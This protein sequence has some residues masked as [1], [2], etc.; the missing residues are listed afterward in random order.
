M[1][2]LAS[3]CVRKP[4]LATVLILFFCVLGV[5]G[6]M[7]LGVDRFPKVDLPFVTVVTRLPGAAPPEVETEVTEKIEEAVN[8]V[9]GIDDLIS[10][11][12]EGVSVVQI[13]FV[14]EKDVDTAVQEVRDRVSQIIPELPRDAETPIVQKLDPDASPVL[15]LSL[16]ADRPIREITELADRKVRPSLETVPGVGQVTLIGGRKRQ[17]NVW[18]DPA[19]MRA[20]G[21]SA[22]E[23]QRAI[24]GQNLMVPGGAIETGPTRLSLRLRGRV[25]KVEE[26]GQLV[27]RERDGHIL[28][29][30]D[31]AR[32][33]DG[34]QEAVTAA[35]QDG[36][37]SVMLSIRKQ[38]GENTVAVVDAIN[39][40]VAQLRPNLPSGYTL[41]VV[42]DNSA[43]TRTSVEA[44]REH[45][46]LGGLFASLVVLLFLG[47][48]RSTLIAALAIPTS[49]VSTFA[50]MKA[51]GF[52]LNTITLLALA[53]AVGIVIDDA[54]V[55]LENI[56][57]HIHEKGEKPF[58][59]AI[60]ATK[61]I[62][63]AVLATTLSLIA[64]FLPMAFMGGIPGRFLSSFG[65]TMAFS[66]AVSLLVSF[67]LT[68][69]L[70]ARWLSAPKGGAHQK[71]FLE[72]V[73]DTFYLPIERAYDRSLRW[74]LRHRWVAVVMA[75]AT[76]GSCVPLMQAVPKGFLPKSDEAQFEV[77]MR[78]P[79][80]TSLASTQLVSERLGRQLRELPEVRSTLVT[81]GDNNERAP[82]LAKIFVQMTHPSTRKESQDQVMARVRRDFTSKLPPEWRVNVSEVSAFSG[83]GTQAAVMM[84]VTGPDFKE[85]T[86]YANTLKE[87]LK[88]I[89]GAVD[90]D[91]NLI[92]G[93][94]EV[95]AFIN[96]SRAADLGVQVSDVA[97]TLQLFVGGVE[98][99]S[100][101][102]N[103]NIYDVRLRAEPTARD[104][105]EALSQL[106]V[107]SA[108]AG[109]VPLMDV[110]HVEHEEGAATINRLNRQRQVLLTANTAP[111][112]GSGT[113]LTQLEQAVKDLKLP[114]GYSAKPLGQSRE[115]GRTMTNFA[116]AFG[117]A[118]VFMYLILAAQFESW[119]HPLTILL[120]LPLTVPFALISL[121]VFRQSLDIYSMLGLMV[122]FGVVKKNSILQIDHA[123]QLRAAGLEKT[124][125]IVVGSRDRLRPIL[126]TTLSFVAGMLPLVTSTGIGAG[127]NRATAGVVVGGQTLSL[128]LTLLV[129]P[130]AYSLLDSLAERAKRFFNSVFS[131]R[132][133]EETG[134]ADVLLAYAEPPHTMAKGVATVSHVTPEALA[135]TAPPARRAEPSP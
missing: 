21:V 97:A 99:S 15:F 77:N 34:E 102:E 59:A 26:L 64:V 116:I 14:L 42:R 43:T 92:L 63:L 28:R 45:L 48:W 7:Q 113:V 124:E 103:G 101:V 11:T 71:P 96:R 18:L 74:M 13:G 68:P 131:P 98:V 86:R 22:A 52:T 2:W 130:V 106:T 3:L 105:V 114:P 79:E 90:A 118:F 84:V 40:R 83:G 110:L 8:T 6:Y 39:E 135:H 112:T 53:L 1:Q 54:I 85:L 123:N 115:I 66:I 38:S 93:K 120:S 117:L 33:E 44:V 23:L 16:N 50:L 82:N 12:S 119:L 30:S 122:L 41:E 17:V 62:G 9:S 126:M 73:T 95:S 25:E 31:V 104:S 58:P 69:M 134:Q 72:R 109:S 88:A 91:T 27:L 60:L 46:V 132:T 56:F 80:G 65:W 47:S 36:K 5:A 133:P 89:P 111:G 67:S 57:R 125:A 129:T 4:V 61:E 32:V 81:I 24:S 87:K 100:Y 19:K 20:A 49:I 76:L 78:M 94:P 37:P 108:R 51:Q 107:P 127:F 35:S 128:V 121:L 10:T 70:S 75:F 55:V 29:V